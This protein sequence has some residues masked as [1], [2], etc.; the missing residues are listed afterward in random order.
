[1]AAAKNIQFQ[2]AKVLLFS[3]KAGEGHFELLI[4]AFRDLFKVI[5]GRHLKEKSPEIMIEKLIPHT[6]P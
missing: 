4:A 1:M 5:I 2:K 6:V 3:Q